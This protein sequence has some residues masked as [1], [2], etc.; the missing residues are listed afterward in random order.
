MKWFVSIMDEGARGGA[1]A[2]VLALSPCFIGAIMGI[3]WLMW[4]GVGLLWVL[5]A[6]SVTTAIR[7][8]DRRRGSTADGG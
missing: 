8:P 2:A 1:T 5:V 3:G 4:L 6:L 7:Y